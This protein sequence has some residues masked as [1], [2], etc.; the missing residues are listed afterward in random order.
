MHWH[1][2]GARK[3]GGGQEEQE[4]EGMMP[5]LGS[6]G[7]LLGRL[8]ASRARK[9]ENPENIEQNQWKSMILPLGAPLGCSLWVSWSLFW[10]YWSAL[11]P[12]LDLSEAVLETS[13]AAL[14]RL[15]CLLGCIGGL[16]GPVA[17]H[18]RS[19]FRPWG[20]RSWSPGICI[21]TLFYICIICTHIYIYTY[22]ACIYVHTCMCINTYIR[23]YL[24]L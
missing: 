14:G 6:L 3:G 11:V 22:N 16:S 13:W 1:E 12:S 24:Q 4:H 15:R 18:L 8:G 7:S 5:S 21:Y 23:I 2:C 17:S 10:E 20:P 9:G 19:G